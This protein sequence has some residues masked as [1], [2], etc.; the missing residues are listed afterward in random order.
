MSTASLDRNATTNATARDVDLRSFLQKGTLV[1]DHSHVWI[2]WGE[3]RRSQE[4]DPL[5]LSIY[6][7]DFFLADPQPWFIFDAYANLDRQEFA[8]ILA[9][10]AAEP[11][12]EWQ[13][14]PMADVAAAFVDIQARIARGELTKAVPFAQRTANLEMDSGVRAWIL[15]NLLRTCGSE[16]LNAYGIWTED[17]GVIGATPELLFA[18]RGNA[19]ISAMALA[20]TRSPDAPSLLLDPKERHE[21]QIVVQGIVERLQAISDVRVGETRELELPHLVHMLTPIDAAGHSNCDFADWVAA[22]HPTAAIGA[23][24]KE[25]GWE[26]LGN[27]PNASMRGRYW[28]PF[29][30][31]PP[32]GE[33]R[34]LV[35]IRNVQWIGTQAMILAGGGIVAESRIDREWREFNAKMDSIQGALGL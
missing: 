20:G 22:L 19:G 21:H 35:A 14:S 4:P 34:C 13:T 28:A 7:P 8:E 6:A 27:Q 2:G 12:V 9:E 32:T 24:P 16:A 10:H 33:S 11:H 17:D 31:V 5:R 23:W 30:I 3:P 26:W 25:A 1:S 15:Q 29:G 18:Q